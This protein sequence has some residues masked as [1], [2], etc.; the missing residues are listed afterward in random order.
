MAPYGYFYYNFFGG[1]VF[2]TAPYQMLDI[3]PGN[4]LYYFNKY[5]FNL[6]HQFEYITDAYAG[7][8]VEHNI[9][10]GLFRFLPI[11]RKLKFRQFWSAKAVVGSLS[12]A[13]KAYNFVGN[14]PYKSLDNNVYME[15]GTGID[16]ILRFFR[17]DFVWGVSPKSI[18]TDPTRRFGVFA[19]FHLNF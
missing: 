5:A 18:V 6:M 10:S 17:V 7:F 15:I 9:G 4:E 3:L 1:K 13:N 8:N 16:N 2:G 14:Y 12:D 11:T 19:S